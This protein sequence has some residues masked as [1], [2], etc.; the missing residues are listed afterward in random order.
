MIA[1]PEKSADYSKPTY[2]NLQ[3]LS[4]F[5]KDLLGFFADFFNSANVF[6]SVKSFWQLE[7]LITVFPSVFANI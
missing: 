6:W 1:L 4:V 5:A 7:I 3:I 2:K